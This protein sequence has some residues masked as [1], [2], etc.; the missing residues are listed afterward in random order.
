MENLKALFLTIV[1]NLITPLVVTLGGI[2]V[3]YFSPSTSEIKLIIINSAL[4]LSAIILILNNRYAPRRVRLV[5]VKGHINQYIIENNIYKHIP[6]P[7]TFDYLGQVFG[8][9][10]KD[11]EE[12]SD[13][14]FKEFSSGS[15]L[16]SITSYCIAFYQKIKT[17]E[18][19]K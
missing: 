18:A 10:W 15:T 7:E 9:D 12:I 14:K 1:G 17:Q 3:S 5:H 4:T 19:Q 16:P 6:D 13:D 11:S 2:A 8:F